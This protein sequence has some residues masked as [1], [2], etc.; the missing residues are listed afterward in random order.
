MSR[1]NAFMLR[2]LLAVIAEPLVY[3]FSG[4]HFLVSVKLSDLG[5]PYF[6]FVFPQVLQQYPLTTGC[7]HLLHGYIVGANERAKLFANIFHLL[8][9]GFIFFIRVFIV[10]LFD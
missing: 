6:G 1:V 4:C 8:V 10:S 2:I 7:P 9:Y 5:L 3:V